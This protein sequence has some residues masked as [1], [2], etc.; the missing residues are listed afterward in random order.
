MRRCL[1]VLEEHPAIDFL[2]LPGHHLYKMDYQKL[3]EAHRT[4][5]ADVTVAVLASVRDY[6]T[7]FG[8]F[9]VDLG[10]RVI[11]FDEKPDLMPVIPLSVKWYRFKCSTV[12]LCYCSY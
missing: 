4:N 7:G 9:N 5:K 12:I 1:W 2:V 6:N 3:I 11:G 10:N 8:S